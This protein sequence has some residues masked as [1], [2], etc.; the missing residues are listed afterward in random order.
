MPKLSQTERR[1]SLSPETEYVAVSDYQ[2][3]VGNSKLN[4][5]GGKS[6][7]VV[8]KAPNGWSLIK[9]GGE[10]GWVP[11]DILNRRRKENVMFADVDEMYQN[12]RSLSVSENM[13]RIKNEVNN[14]VAQQQGDSA[15]EHYI[16]IGAYLTSDESG[17][18]FKENANVVVVETNESGWWYIRIGSDEGWAP[19]TYLK[20]IK[21]QWESKKTI[22]SGSDS[23]SKTIDISLSP[24]KPN[25]KSQ[26]PQSYENVDV[27]DGVK[28]E[29]ARNTKVP[30]V[31]K[32]RQAPRA[33]AEVSNLSP[34]INELKAAFT[35]Q[36]RSPKFVKSQS[37]EAGNVSANES[38]Q[39]RKI[40]EPAK[41]PPRPEKGPSPVNIKGK[42]TPPVPTRPIT[43]S[44]RQTPSPQN[45]AIR[46]SPQVP[47]RP[48][49][50]K[51]EL[52]ETMCD[53]SDDDEGMLS[54]K[55]GEKVQVLEKDDGGWWLAMIGVKKGWVPS[56]FLT[57]L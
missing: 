36:R 53:Y 6:Y 9:I 48:D 20:P 30:P 54:F 16:T 8:E 15:E 14:N 43:S 56:N 11:S 26:I 52:Y 5:C 18:S 24:Q 27:A 33:S 28:D 23:Q 13:E 10:E 31:Q 39:M 19:S 37:I 57:K 22:T 17:I 47:T 7:T 32:P 45:K 34:P 1:E 41:R 4:V 35:K 3:S 49:A 38:F 21:K 25:R 40:S 51:G 46:I 42:V 2:M 50:I 44:V 12:V 55:A 29:P